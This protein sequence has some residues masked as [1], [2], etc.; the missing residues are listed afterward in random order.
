[1]A[2]LGV[3]NNITRAQNRRFCG[4]IDVQVRCS[5]K[6]PWKKAVTAYIYLDATYLQVAWARQCR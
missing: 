1:M 3:Q 6:D 4:G 2:A 5:R